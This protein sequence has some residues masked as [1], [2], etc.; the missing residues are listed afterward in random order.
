MCGANTL[1]YRLVAELTELYEVS[2][3]AIV[4]N[5]DRDH[6]PQITKILGE[7]SVIAVPAI[8]EE[9][10]RAAGVVVARGIALVDGDDQSN[11]HTALRAQALNSGIR[12]ALRM[13]NQ[14]LGKHVERLLNDC[15]A[16]SRSATAAP[17][18]VNAALRRPNSVQ[19]GTRSVS[20]EIGL[21][22][23]PADFLC[24]IADRIDK[25]DLARMRLLP[26]A[27]GP[28]ATWIS[29]VARNPPV[30]PGGAGAF[31][32]TPAGT[33]VAA[34]PPGTRAVLR[35]LDGVRPHTPAWYSRL[36]WRI[37]DLR[38]L[39]SAN[40]LSRVFL[41]AF[42]AVLASFFVVWYLNGH[43]AWA[44]YD[45]LLD[46]AGAAQP[47]VLGQPSQTGGAWQRAAQVV[48]TFCGIMFIPAITAIMLDALARGR[49]GLARRPSAGVRGHVVVFGLGNVGTRVATLIH[50]L[51]IPVVCIERDPTARGIAAVRGMEIPVL[52]GE[53]PLED[54]LRKA[55]VHRSRA[56]L[57]LTGDDAANL[58]AALE[59]RALAPDVRVVL[60]LFDDDFATQVYRTFTNAASRS[61]SYLAAPAFA[62]ALMGREVL[63]TLSVYRHVVLVA[64]FVTEAGS[65][66][67]GKPIHEVEVPGEVRV[68]AV[69]AKG[70]RDYAW[71][72]DRSRCFAEGDKYVLLTTR[73][74]LGRHTSRVAA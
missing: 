62:A 72:L 68:I 16:L 47:D 65:D 2:V 56:V 51:G 23:D 49:A 9:A 48:T 24:T 3:V 38:R 25:Q 22:G 66:L 42:A 73:A 44:I 36:R 27:P 61:V 70:A 63:G 37:V 1:A 43:L 20:V 17:A 21:G 35:F 33:P 5:R 57:A 54:Q 29:E 30:A 53:A 46:M 13:Y 34:P 40:Q 12:V 39:L 69:R 50:R 11:I 19:V 67:V 64:E 55:R 14:R 4:P 74:G 41:G 6:A 18:F 71:R 32:F 58:E 15:A 28:A 31:A 8:T 7:G 45:T 10:L 59:A 60:R 52:V 26:D